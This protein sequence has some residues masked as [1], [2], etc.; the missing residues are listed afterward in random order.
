MM[1]HSQKHSTI[2]FIIARLS[3]A[4]YTTYDFAQA[5]MKKLFK[6]KINYPFS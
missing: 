4:K 1:S 2:I 6:Q 3:K 5:I